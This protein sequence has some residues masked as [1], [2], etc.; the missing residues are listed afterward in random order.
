MN[1]SPL[2]KDRDSMSLKNVFVA[3]WK[4]SFA[5]ISS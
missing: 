2:E 4:F 3:N 5:D 1:N